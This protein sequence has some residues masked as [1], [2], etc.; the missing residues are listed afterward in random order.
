VDTL[1]RV[2]DG[3]PGAVD[4]CAH[5]HEKARSAI[6]DGRLSRARLLAPQGIRG[7]EN[8]V[9]LEQIKRTGD[10]FFAY[11][12]EPWVLAGA[13]VHIS[14]VGQSLPAPEVRPPSSGS[15]LF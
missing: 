7:G 12:D 8:R 5:W 9:V 15:R 14:F 11:A 2:Y 1:R 6:E 13:A 4:L 10:V 3:L